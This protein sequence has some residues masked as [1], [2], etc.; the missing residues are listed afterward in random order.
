LVAAIKQQS[1][2]SPLDKG[3]MAAQTQSNE[4]FKY[5]NIWL[6]PRSAVDSTEFNKALSGY[7]FKHVCG[8]VVTLT[9]KRGNIELSLDSRS[10]I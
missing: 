10:G 1:I 9:N 3:K 7:S 2:K 6:I 4:R 5:L 8:E